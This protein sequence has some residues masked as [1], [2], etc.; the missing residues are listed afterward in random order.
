MPAY[1]DAKD[2]PSEELHILII[3]DDEV[4]RMIIRRSMQKAKLQAQVYEATTAAEGLQLVSCRIYNCIFID[5]KLPD[6]D[7]LELM[8]Q[9]HRKGVQ[10]PILIVTSHGDERLAANAIRFGAADYLP[11][12]LLTPEGISRS[13]R[14]AIRLQKV[15]ASRK[16]AEERL[17]MT[18]HQLEFVISN[19]PMI[20]TNINGDG[21]F[22][23]A[24]GAG[25]SLLNLNKDDLLGKAYYD[26]FADSPRLLNR[27]ERAL[28]GETVQSIDE[29][30]GSYFKAHHVPILSDNNSVT[31]VT[32]F[33]YDITE[34]IINER[35]LIQAKELAEQSVRVK[36]QFIA[37]ISH[38][39][40]TPMN[41]I[42]GLTSILQ[43]S[44]LDNEQK[45]YLKAIQTSAQNLMVIIND[46]LDFSKISAQQYS[47]EEI[48][49][50]IN[51][52]IQETVDLMDV[53]AKERNNTLST[54]TDKKVPELLQGDPLR[55]KQVLLNL[56][57]NA[58]KFTENGGIKLLVHSIEE[59]ADNVMLEFTVEDTGI[60]IPADKLQAIFE[61]F[62]Q[63]SN[64][65]T[66]KY[67]GT[68][69]GL[70]ISKSLVELQ[71]GTIAV[72]SQAMVGSAFTFSLPFKKV[73][74]SSCPKEQDEA[75]DIEY[76]H[77]EL[78]GLRIL[79][80]EDNEINQLLI[81]TVL[82]DWEVSVD[83]V[84]NG[85][86]ALAMF[87]T[88]AYD[89]ILMDMQMP[90][91]DG[92][93]AINRIRTSGVANAALP[94]IALTAHATTGEVEKCIAAGANAYVSKPFEPEDL[95]QTIMH[96]TR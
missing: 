8:E 74:I 55:L 93:E 81:N 11:K 94:I 38:E 17:R 57:G 33:A 82:S 45:K 7:G 14:T 69:L 64:D 86:E 19:T 5:F 1:L 18:Q 58:T 50:N 62:N 92:Y 35:E 52:L 21:I 36:E 71:G 26:V 88:N 53:R 76:Q 54:Y 78:K 49:F 31:G 80:A 12:A 22:K 68:G 40:R 96:L 72:R 42:L 37:N 6:M 23:F 15:E 83:T 41:G 39:I 24:S 67:G 4:D 90:E 46:L 44:E 79:L 32:S 9:I 25:F 85:L 20:V 65:T 63:G 77:G 34:S 91:M 30:N 51:D 47:F 75:L 66:R 10:A 73:N 89:I 27:V 3:D 70:T 28:A 16:E 60:G 29:T 87:D 48:T 56:I 43:K 95:F 59:R 61:S 2:E 84:A 13:I